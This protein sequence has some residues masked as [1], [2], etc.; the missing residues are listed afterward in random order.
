VLDVRHSQKLGTTAGNK[1]SES[2]DEKTVQWSRLV[3][4]SDGVCWC[5]G[6]V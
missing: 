2:G 5:W 1:A 4:L 3:G 6:D